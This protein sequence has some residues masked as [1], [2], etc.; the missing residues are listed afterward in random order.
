MDLHQALAELARDHG[1]ALFL[2]ASAF[3]GALDDYLDEGTASGGTINLL[4]DAVRLGALDG[5]LGM[6][7][8][9]AGTTEAVEAAGLRLARDRGS[10]D[11]RGCQWACAVLGYALGRVPME[12]VRG[13]DPDAA[14]SAPQWPAPSG[15]P[16]PPTAPT[17]AP[18]PAQP[19][20]QAPYQS[21]TPQPP[22][23]QYPPPQQGYPAGYQHAYRSTGYP[24]PPAP[25]KSRTGL[26]VGLAALAVVLVIGIVVAVVALAGGDEPTPGADPSSSTSKGSGK[27]KETES[28]GTGPTL[29]G[30]GYTVVLPSDE[31]TDAT[32]VF[33]EADPS[34]TGALDKAAMWGE[35]IQTARANVIIEAGSANGSSDPEDL[36]DDWRG[37]LVGGDS[38]AVV[39]DLPERQIDGKRAIGVQISRTNAADVEI[40]QVAYLTVSGNN[41]YS[42]ALS[43]KA[44]DNGVDAAFETMLGGWTW[45]E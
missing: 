28:P 14:T 6:L 39:S 37:L 33:R 24:P 17:T 42:I 2:D 31:W 11:T 19:T 8:S 43:R 23:P 25:K 7:D 40:Y 20:A 29:D 13:L 32:D 3:R 22:T 4:T 27:T 26:L 45:D 21:P 35:S 15:K 36:E 34:S 10:T 5:M 12:L 18:P 9:G 30:T 1:T 41:A 44:S 16:A 38:S